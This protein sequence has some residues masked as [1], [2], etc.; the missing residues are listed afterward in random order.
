M[1]SMEIKNI[2]DRLIVS[3][4]AYDDEI[5]TRL[6]AERK[7]LLEIS[8]ALDRSENSVAIRALRLGLER[9]FKVGSR[10]GPRVKKH[11]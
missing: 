8:K 4:S 11:A 10:R 6:W 1:L 9:R 3:W 5:L 7:T 2:P